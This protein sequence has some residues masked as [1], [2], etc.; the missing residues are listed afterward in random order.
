MKHLSITIDD[1][2]ADWLKDKKNTSLYINSLIRAAAG[3][4][5]IQTIEEFATQI[6]SQQQFD[7]RLKTTKA[8]ENAE[9]VLRLLNEANENPGNAVELGMRAYKLNCGLREL[10]SRLPKEAYT[11]LREKIRRMKI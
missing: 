1:D 10:R 7:E 9:M 4:E 3:T 11:K 8:A 5:G 6:E 2:L